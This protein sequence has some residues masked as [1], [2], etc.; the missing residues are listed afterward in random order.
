MLVVVEPE[1]R[2][3]PV[4]EGVGL[5]LSLRL[6]SLLAEDPLVTVC[7]PL[8][9]DR[10][11]TAFESAVNFAAQLGYDY[12]VEPSIQ[13]ADSRWEVR[14]TITAANGGEIIINTHQVFD[15][16]AHESVMDAIAAWIRGQISGLLATRA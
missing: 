12:V 11:A 9:R 2:G 10:I 3:Q 5:G 4:P 6:V 15:P 1:V 16:Q 14:M 8:R 7:G 13:T